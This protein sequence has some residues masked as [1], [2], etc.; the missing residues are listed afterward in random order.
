MKIHSII[1]LMLIFLTASL[2]GFKQGANLGVDPDENTSAFA[3][4]AES[5]PSAQ[6]NLLLIQ[7]DRSESGLFTLQSVWLMAYYSN[8]PRVDLLPIYPSFRASEPGAGQALVKNFAFTAE[9]KP[10]EAFWLKMQE[11]N[12]WWNA[13]ILLDREASELLA[14]KFEVSSLPHDHPEWSSFNEINLPYP[15]LKDTI[16]EQA[17][18]YASL[19][20]NFPNRPGWLGFI[21]LYLPLH[22]NLHTN[23]APGQ[24]W[25]V[26]QLLES[27]GQVLK[28]NFPSLQK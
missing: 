15:E 23:L 25:D 8:S 16:S 21:R 24:L 7:V 18:L 5:A 11:L 22:N 6:H 3:I 19:C 27:H 28:C 20:R 12:I 14:E 1:G 2:V 4:S 13:Y 10:V 17:S 26:W 9:G